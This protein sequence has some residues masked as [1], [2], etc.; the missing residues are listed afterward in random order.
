MEQQTDKAADLSQL[1]RTEGLQCDVGA[2]IICCFLI[3]LIAVPLGIAVYENRPRRGGGRRAKIDE[4]IARLQMKVE[5]YRAQTGGYPSGLADLLTAVAAGVDV[6]GDG[7]VDA[8]DEYGPWLKEIPTQPDGSKYLY[9]PSTGTCRGG[10]YKQN[11][12]KDPYWDALIKRLT[13][14]F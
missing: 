6:N 2:I 14:F 13:T 5:L 4:G 1:Y 9:D 3:I 11:P 7:V 10:G 8:S 12:W